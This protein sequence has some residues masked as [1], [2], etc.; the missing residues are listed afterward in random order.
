MQGGARIERGEV[1]VPFVPDRER[2]RVATHIRST[3]ITSSV[4]SLRTRGLY[5]AYCVHLPAARRDDMPATVAGSWLPVSEGVVH[6]GACDALRLPAA[7]LI[8]IGADAATRSTNSMLSMVK[9]LAAGGGVTP[10]TILGQTRRLWE[11][12]F[13]GS[14]V[15]VFKTGPKEARFEIVAWPLARIEYNRVSFRGILR[16]LLVPFCTQVYVHE[17][18]SLCTPMTVG[19]RIAWA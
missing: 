10:W 11:R 18:T 5:D 16:G 9:R 8:E 3:M 4:A 7:V 19:F 17:A 1:I 12:A 6:Y 13:Q 2:A 15:G 14:S